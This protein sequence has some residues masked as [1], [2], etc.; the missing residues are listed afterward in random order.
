MAPT[1]LCEIRRR[2]R[3]A[4]RRALNQMQANLQV[5]HLVLQ[6]HYP[7]FLA[8]LTALPPSSLYEA[9]SES[10]PGLESLGSFDNKAEAEA[11][12]RLSTQ[13]IIAKIDSRISELLLELQSMRN[14]KRARHSYGD[15]NKKQVR[16][17]RYVRQHMR[18]ISK[19]LLVGDYGVIDLGITTQEEAD[20]IFQKHN[21]VLFYLNQELH[22]ALF[23]RDLGFPK[24]LREDY[25]TAV[26]HYLATHGDNLPQGKSAHSNKYPDRVTYSG[27][28]DL[29]VSFM[30]G[31]HHDK[32]TNL[33][34]R[35]EHFGT[36]DKML[37]A[38]D[39]LSH[40]LFVPE[41]A[42]GINGMLFEGGPYILET[43][44]RLLDE[45]R[46]FMRCS[47]SLVDY[48]IQIP[49]APWHMF[50]MM[51]WALNHEVMI[52]DSY[53]GKFENRRVEVIGSYESVLQNFVERDALV[54]AGE[55]TA[56]KKTTADE[57]TTSK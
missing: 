33:K 26:S 34:L 37:S 2:E 29:S 35:K 38:T 30:S 9:L 11:E 17:S 44:W 55:K 43:K 5:R 21:A 24:S 1:D 13:D 8:E 28:L 19:A 47:L 56:A 7:E 39:Y 3:I 6:H 52:N 45:A 41:L 54:S 23:Q 53:K 42:D 48:G 22:G 12:Q 49:L 10:V 36:S 51:A 50:S 20:T 40:T 32:K 4:N 57:E 16:Q 18:N 25:N 27:K 14:N 31:H 46:F 15:S